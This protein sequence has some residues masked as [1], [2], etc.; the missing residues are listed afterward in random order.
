MN[1]DYATLVSLLPYWWSV[2][3]C[4]SF[5]SD[6]L[7]G[8]LKLSL[9][10]SWWCGWL[11]NLDIECL[12]IAP[13][14]LS[15]SLSFVPFFLSP[16]PLFLT[17]Y[18]SLWTWKDNE[19]KLGRGFISLKNIRVKNA[20]RNTNFLKIFLLYKRTFEKDVLQNIW[21]NKIVNKDIQCEILKS[22]L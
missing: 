6:D 16:L 14:P 7:C 19:G 3:G 1:R 22:N 12:W 4:R 5:D 15:F 8:I 2:A 20:E 21:I 10:W 17:P 11:L 13:L 18:L 9:Y